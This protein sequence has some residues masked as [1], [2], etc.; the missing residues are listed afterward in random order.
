MND[1]F[2]NK[3]ESSKVF[4]LLLGLC[5]HVVK[6]VLSHGNGHFDWLISARQGVS[7]LRNQ[8]LYRLAKTKDLRLSIL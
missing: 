1:L 5:F 8:I 6:I 2:S 4:R 7:F 3:S